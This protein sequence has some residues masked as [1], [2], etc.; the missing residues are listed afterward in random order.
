MRMNLR[1]IFPVDQHG[2]TVEFA[3]GNE[4]EM[5]ERVSMIAGKRTRRILSDAAYGTMTLSQL[6]EAAYI[7]GMTDAGIASS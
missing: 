7:Q 4:S 1:P 3:K 6:L 5:L 2:R